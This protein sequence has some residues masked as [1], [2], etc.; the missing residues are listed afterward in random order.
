SALFCH[1]AHVRPVSW[2]SSMYMLLLAGDGLPNALVVMAVES[3]GATAQSFT[4]SQAGVLTTARH[5]NARIVHV[6][7]G[8]LQEALDKGRICIVA[9]FQGVNKDTRDV[10]SLGRGG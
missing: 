9:G 10:T 6:T 1:A 5:G 7:P 8:R 3:L 4:G 2:K